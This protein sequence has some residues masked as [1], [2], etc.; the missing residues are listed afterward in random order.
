MNRRF[1]LL[2]I[3]FL[4]A[5]L[6]AQQGSQPFSI[7][8]TGQSFWR[9][10]DAVQAIGN[11]DGTIAMAPG[12]YR[13]CA[14]QR[15]GRITYRAET[16]G[17]V[18]FDGTTCEGKAALV[19]GGQAAE[20]DGIIFQNM[21]VADRN[22]SGIRLEQGDLKI[23]NATFRN[24]EQGILTANNPAGTIIVDRSTFSGLGG[25]PD[26]MCSHSIYVGE[27]GRLI[28]TRSRFERGTG[29][30][31]VKSR[32]ARSEIS[33]NSFDDTRGRQ[34]N[35]MIDLPAGSVGSITRNEFV[36]GA[37]KENY[38]AFIAVGAEGITHPSA[39]LS[40]S[41]NRASIAPGVNRSTTFVADWTH[42]PLR[43]G[44]N[45]LGQG[46]KAFDER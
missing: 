34:T 20:V 10:S 39:G 46:L 13:Q 28:V 11:G 24:S 16:P 30:H 40:I 41:N 1:A 14:V 5:P 25:C 29:G 36:Q 33:D 15:A 4:A 42:E 12:T 38:S 31:Y 18:I 27:Y 8:E 9:L 19:L 6:G 17:T 23:V 32:A 2:P 44:A 45:V 3:L 7:E 26:G 22:G 35:Y 37:S 21:R 43:L